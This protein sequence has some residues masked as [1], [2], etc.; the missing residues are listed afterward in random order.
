MDTNQR[1]HRLRTCT[2]KR[3]HGDASRSNGACKGKMHLIYMTCATS[4][5]ERCAPEMAA[6]WPSAAPATFPRQLPSVLPYRV[7]RENICELSTPGRPVRSNLRSEV[8]ACSSRESCY[9]VA[10]EGRGAQR[11]DISFVSSAGRSFVNPVLTR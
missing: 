10:R 11:L 2:E 7:S 3:V 5:Y 9:W 8:M 1:L 4:M 6:G